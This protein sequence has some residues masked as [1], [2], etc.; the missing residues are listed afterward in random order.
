VC[1][2]IQDN[3]TLWL[4]ECHVDGFRWDTPATMMQ[5]ND[6]SYIP[7]A[8]S[9]I[10]AINTMIHYQLHR[11]NQHLPRMCIITTDST[12][13]GTPP[14]LAR[15]PGADASDSSRDM[16]VIANAVQYNVRY[17]GTAGT[18]RVAFLESHD[19][20]GDLTAASGW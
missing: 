3:F 19:V 16:S 6:G 5:G 2:F 12:A 1:N 10:Y 14:F 8:D 7:A 15:S 9:L 11:Q 4:S 13:P 18:G 17:G 20:V